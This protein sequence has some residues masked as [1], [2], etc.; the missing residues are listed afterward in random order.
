MVASRP[1]ASLDAIGEPFLHMLDLAQFLPV[2][3]PLWTDAMI[4]ET[5][6]HLAGCLIGIEADLR[7]ELNLIA[8]HPGAAVP[9]ATA[10]DEVQAHPQLIGIDLLPH[11][12]IR[13]AVGLIGRQA[14]AAANGSTAPAGEDLAWLIADEDSEIAAQA[15]ALARAEQRWTAPGGER[16]PMLADLPAEYFADLA[17]TVAALAARASSRTGEMAASAAMDHIADATHRII[18]RHDEGD[19]P[20]A[21]AAMMARMMRGRPDEGHMLGQALGHRRI[22]LFAALAGVRVGIAAEAILH[23]LVHAAP[24]RLAGLCHALGGSDTDFRHL[25]IQLRPVRAGLNDAHIVALTADYDGM[26]E[27]DAD[28]AIAGLRGPSDLRAKLALIDPVACG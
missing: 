27:G 11:M 12:R 23:A 22:L 2:G 13:A 6:R 9:A 26:S 14:G 3:A 5:R 16:S 18:A 7:H 28:A 4:S 15:S 20:V 10:W 19:T 21:R 25:L 8:G 24:D 17:W 1:L